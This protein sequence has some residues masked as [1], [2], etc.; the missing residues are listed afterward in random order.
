MEKEIWQLWEEKT[1][2]PWSEAKNRGFTD[3]SFGANV[4]IRKELES[5]DVSRFTK[6]QHAAKDGRASSDYVAPQQKTAEVGFQPT[7]PW[8]DNYLGETNRH[9]DSGTVVDKRTNTAY[10]LEKGKVVKSFPILSGK[11]VEGN[12]NN[13]GLDYLENNPKSRAT[14]T[15]TYMMNPVDDIYGER[16]FDLQPIGAF[17]RPAPEVSDIATHVTYPG[18]LQRRTPL[19]N[20]SP[21]DRDVTYGC[22]N[23]RKEDIKYMADRYK[24]KDTMMV[25]DSKNPQDKLFMR[26]IKQQGGYNDNPFLNTQYGFPT[27]PNQPTAEDI[28]KYQAYQ[29][30]PNQGVALDPNNLT[31]EGYIPNA[32]MLERM[33]QNRYNNRPS[34]DFNNWSFQDGYDEN[35]NAIGNV[36]TDEGNNRLQLENPYGGIGLDQSLY[37]AGQGYGEGDPFKAVA[38]TGLTLLKGARNFLSGYA[39]AKADKEAK[40]EMRRRQFENNTA[41]EYMREGGEI[42]TADMLTGQYIINDPNGGNVEIEDKEFVKDMQTGDIQKAVGDTHENGGISTNLSEAKI[43]SD[44]TKIGAKNAKELKKQYDI[45]VKANDTFASAMDKYNKKVGVTKA[46]DEQAKVIERLGKNE[47]VKDENTKRLNETVLTKEI[48]E[49]EAEINKLK[50]KTDMVFEN[51]FS[52]QESIPKISG[53]NEVLDKNGNPIEVKK[54]GGYVNELAT[55]YGISPERA[56]ELI[57]L[58][59][60][61]EMAQEQVQQHPDPQQIMGMVAQALQQGTPVEEVIQALVEMGIPEQSAVQMVEQ[62]ASQV[63]GQ[64]QEG[65]MPQEGQVMQEGGYT[66]AQKDARLMDYYKQIQSLGYEGKMQIGDM[67]NWVSEKYPNEVEKYFT[68][69]NQPMTA[70]HIDTIKEKYKDV[71]TKAGIPS[72]K[73]SASY[74]K[75]EKDKLKEILGKNVNQDFWLEGFKDNKWDWRFPTVSPHADMK[76]VQTPTEITASTDIRQRATTAVEEETANNK[77]GQAT[78]RVRKVFPN[79]PYDYVLPPSAM[80]VPYKAEVSLGRLDPVKISPEPSLVEAERQ[81]K[82]AVNQLASA[83]LSPQV[84]QALLAQGLG[85]TQMSANDAIYKAESFN[86]D[87]QFKTDQFNLGQRTKEDLT[88]EQFNLNYEQKVAQTEANQERDLRRYFNQLNANQRRDFKDVNDINLTNAMYEQ[89]QSDGSNVYFMNNKAKDN[90]LTSITQA[91]FDAMTPEQQLAFTKKQTEVSKNAA[92]MSAYKSTNNK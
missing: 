82:G 87:N 42:K 14:P 69:S 52:R 43:L 38:G 50:P 44:Y 92:L 73:S 81:R 32:E 26:N 41:P 54:E 85:N 10:I 23:C 79:L 58:Q 46:T 25:V 47:A 7:F 9:L 66:K 59:E 83:N 71:F 84:E 78:D 2:L 37:V 86:A 15:G 91:Q 76:V 27:D 89:F 51:L 70:K 16:G 48:E 53:G 60:G 8:S 28:Q 22:V 19:Y 80:K 20:K 55:K 29:A 21:R 13:M 33:K 56:N 3:G 18:E 12:T 57:R 49:K 45:S 35:G 36:N 30:S 88:N 31:Q 63:Q 77:D 61:G 62:V 5:G 75:E 1:G 40:A 90:G 68:E 24:T 34:F 11:N 17:G 6:K 65:Q 67:Q 64:S 72:N 74:T 39:T 4:A